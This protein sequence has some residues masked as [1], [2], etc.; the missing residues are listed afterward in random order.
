[1]SSDYSFWG[2]MTLSSVIAGLRDLPRTAKVRRGFANPHSYRGYYEELAV[3]PAEAVSVASMI[4]ALESA[5]G[6][7]FYGWKGGEY[8]MGDTTGV[9]IAVEGST[10]VPVTDHWLDLIRLEISSGVE[11]VE[12]GD[13]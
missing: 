8:L 3:E 2:A 10:G 13:E 12:G 4:Q 9:W 5:K 11:R 1:M 7:T 6:E